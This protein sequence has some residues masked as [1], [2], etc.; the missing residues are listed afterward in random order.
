MFFDGIPAAQWEPELQAPRRR[1]EAMKTD[2]GLFGLIVGGIVVLAIVL[3][4][5]GG[6]DFGGKKT[7]ES[8]QDLPPVE[9]TGR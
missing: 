5:F 2:S 7:I 8:D 3:F 1:L 4:I 9:T 6:G